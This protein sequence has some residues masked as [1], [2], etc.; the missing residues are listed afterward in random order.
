MARALEF[1]MYKL[2]YDGEGPPKLP[3]LMKRKTADDILW[4]SKS[5]DARLLAQFCRLF[6]RM[7]PG[8]LDL[9]LFVAKKMARRKAA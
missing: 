7:E 6:S 9:V 2:F 3:N 8:D 4:G 5:K 1:P